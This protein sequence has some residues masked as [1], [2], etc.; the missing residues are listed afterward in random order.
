VNH[1]ENMIFLYV[2]LRTYSCGV[3]AIFSA[4]LKDDIACTIKSPFKQPNVQITRRYTQKNN[5]LIILNTRTLVKLWLITN[6]QNALS[7]I[8]FS[9][10]RDYKR[11]DV[12]FVITT[13][14]NNMHPKKV[15]NLINFMQINS[16]CYIYI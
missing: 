1:R 6:L 3:E 2:H 5:Q 8:D 10:D 15:F 13:Y 12:V 9:R 16:V 11:V 14:N 4:A 7:K